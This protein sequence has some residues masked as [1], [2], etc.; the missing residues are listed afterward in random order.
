MI[1][2]QNNKQQGIDQT[3][4]LMADQVGSPLGSSPKSRGTLWI[5]AALGACAAIAAGVFVVSSGLGP[6]Q[7]TAVE[8]ANAVTVAVTAP[9][10]NSVIAADQ[11]T[12]RGTVSPAN[13]TVQVQGQPA[14][15]GNGVFTGTATLHGGKTTIDV[16]GSAPRE[17]PG[18][19]S[20]VV[21]RQSSAGP[22]ATPRA[23][24]PA[25]TPEA[26]NPG[27]GETACA[28]GLWV[29]PNTT[30]AFAENVRNAYEA[31]G[32]GAVSAYSPVTNTTYVMSCSTGPSV[33]C[34][35][36]NAASV[37]FPS[38]SAGYPNETGQQESGG[39]SPTIPPP[40]SGSN[41][42]A[43]G[44]G[45]AVGPDTTCAFAENVRSAYESSGPGTVSAYS[46][47]TKKTYA[48]SCVAGSPVVCT[49]GNNAS[50][51]I[52]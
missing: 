36:G 45:L 1:S 15:V 5:A 41:E 18:S 19:T 35:G 40:S 52:P 31:S 38:Q 50:V 20:I 49:G 44:N 30:C 3:E 6:T 26:P 27:S 33:V 25:A 32:P 16:I 51:Y 11:V 9:T 42:T 48:M 24:P 28:G 14:A 21:A 23:V 46:P 17:T 34:T 39:S 37:Y 43:C 8:Q 13:A 4:Q 22:G 29:G 12:V 7:K 2:T 10:S 47:V